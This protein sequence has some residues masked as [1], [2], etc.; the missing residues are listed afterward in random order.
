MTM[1]LHR[2]KPVAN[3]SVKQGFCEGLERFLS[4]WALHH[5]H[6]DL[7]ASLFLE[8]G[9]QWMY[10]LALGRGNRR[11]KAARNRFRSA[12]DGAH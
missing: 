3:T 4:E 9:K 8:L 7:L 5:D 2:S 11:L 12:T 6:N 1:D 10:L